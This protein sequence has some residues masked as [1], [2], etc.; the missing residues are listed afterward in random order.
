MANQTSDKLN[1]FHFGGS[2][3]R[4]LSK[5][6]TNSQSQMD[7]STRSVRPSID[8]SEPDDMYPPESFQSPIQSPSESSLIFERSVMDPTQIYQQTSC[9]RCGHKP[10]SQGGINCNHQSIVNLPSHY[11]MENFVSPCLD[12]TTQ[13]LTDKNADL[14]NVDMVY[15]RRPSSVLGLNMALG[16]SRSSLAD[17]GQGGQDQ[18]SPPRAVPKTHSMASLQSADQSDRPPAVSFYSFADMMQSENPNPRR[19]SISQ[20]LSSSFLNS[21][22]NSVSNPPG[23]FNMGASITP[24]RAPLNLRTQSFSSPFTLNRHRSASKKFTL[25]GDHS[26]GSSDSES[27]YVHTRKNSTTSRSSKI[28]NRLKKTLSGASNIQR[29][30][31]MASQDDATSLIS[32]EDG[33]DSLV[34]SSIGERLRK[35]TGEINSGVLA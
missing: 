14:E 27:D 8:T 21:R 25:N 16:R 6:R 30:S 26:P 5:Q 4:R 19:P 17:Q 9:P 12:A 35:N 15:S 33:D 1:D 11:S 3:N 23:N 20:S 22:S 31:T 34:I 13:I 7:P 32:E 18:S 28:S 2:G 10:S 24:Q 29:T